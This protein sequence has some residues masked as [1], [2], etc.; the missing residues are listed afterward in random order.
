MKAVAAGD[1][2]AGELVSVAA[3]FV[4][5]AVSYARPVAGVSLSTD[6]LLAGYH[7]FYA[8]EPFVHVTDGSPATKAT[9]VSN[10]AHLTVFE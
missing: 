5:G 6:G 9:L 2:V 1:E 4:A 3:G 7:D 8:D 10:A